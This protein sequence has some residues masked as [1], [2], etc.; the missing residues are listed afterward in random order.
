MKLTINAVVGSAH[1]FNTL[2]GTILRTG[3]FLRD[4][5]APESEA[6]VKLWGNGLFNA[7]GDLI[8]GFP[9]ISQYNTQTKFE[10][11][12]HSEDCE[13]LKVAILSL[14]DKDGMIHGR[15]RLFNADRMAQ[16]VDGVVTGILPPDCLTREFGIRQQAL[17]LKYYKESTV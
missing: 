2:M 15:T 7:A 17:Y 10:A 12:N 11:V 1:W 13:Q 6:I 9:L 3:E 8:E 14:A 16:H 4:H 5:G